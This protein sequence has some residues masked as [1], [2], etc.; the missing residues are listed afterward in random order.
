M[1]L[2]SKQSNK[3]AFLSLL[4]WLLPGEGQILAKRSI[5][6]R[7]LSFHRG[8][9]ACHG[10]VWSESGLQVT[11]GARPPGPSWFLSLREAV[12]A[13]MKCLLS[14]AVSSYFPWVW[15]GSCGLE[16]GMCECSQESSEKVGRAAHP[17]ASGVKLQGVSPVLALPQRA[18]SFPI[19]PHL[20]FHHGFQSLCCC[21]VLP[22]E[23]VH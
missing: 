22:N 20:H 18:V 13:G 19:P 14:G 12:F 4:P 8:V 3:F 15:D 10:L 6:T 17:G 11:V 7:L 21:S 5:S 23:C 2:N 16:W 1:G 9:Q